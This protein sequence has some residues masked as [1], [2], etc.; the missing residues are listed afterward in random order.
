MTIVMDLSY[1]GSMKTGW[2]VPAGMVDKQVAEA[3]VFEAIWRQVNVE[4]T[5]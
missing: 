1:P 3:Q 5:L 4:T 2:F